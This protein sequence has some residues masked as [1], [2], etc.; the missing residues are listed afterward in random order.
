MRKFRNQIFLNLSLLLPQN[1]KQ[2][3]TS[4]HILI[5]QIIPKNKNSVNPNVVLKS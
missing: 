2:R 3:Q 4:L 1:R 5:T